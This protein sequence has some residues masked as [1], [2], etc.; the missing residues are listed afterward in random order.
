MIDTHS[1]PYLSEFDNDCAEVMARAVQA[2]VKHIVLPNV[3]VHTIGQMRELHAEFPKL[4]SM[5]MG[6]HPTEVGASWQEDLAAIDDEW[7]RNKTDY[8]AVGEVGIDLYWDKTFADEQMQVFDIQARRAVD[9]DLP[10]IIHCRDGLDE[11][12]EVLSGLEIKPRAVFHSFGGSP[13]QVEKIRRIGDFYFGLNGVVTFKNAR[14]DNTV[15]EITLDRILLET[16]AP[17][18]APV[19][20]RGQR[21]EPEY[22]VYTCQQIA[23]I[24]NL[25]NNFVEH[26]TSVNATKLFNIKI[27]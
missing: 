13:D 8:I 27:K 14:L 4:T 19:P 18:L 9:I 22:I 5:A 17:Y 7:E 1:H 26:E 16:D 24:L 12:L 2:G 23:S 10:L 20:R 15:K 21:N 25:D 11:T 6:L 3:D